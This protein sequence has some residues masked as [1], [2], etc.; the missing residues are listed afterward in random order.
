MNIFLTGASGFV[1]GEVAARLVTAGHSI[2]ALVRQSPSIRANDNSPVEGTRRV[3][4]DVAVAEMGLAPAEFRQIARDHDLVI[5]C[6]ATTRFDLNDDAYAAINV[7]GAT[8]AVALARAGDIPLLHISTAYVCGTR[9]GRI[10]ETDPLPDGGWANGYERSKAAAERIVAAS[11]LR[12]AIARPSIVVG[13]SGTGRVRDF[14][15]VYGLFKMMAEGRFRRIPATADASLDF[16][17]IDYVAAGIA[18][19]ADR[20]SSASGVY[21]L[22]SGAPI[23]LA[24]AVRTVAGFANLQAAI[25]VDPGEYDPTLLTGR[26]RWIFD[27]AFCHYSSYTSRNPQFDD[28]R[29][30][31]FTRNPR[32]TTDLEYFRKLIQHSIDAGFVRTA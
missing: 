7:G 21:H 1:G 30:R 17:P 19:L 29:F 32:P 18:E 16:V 15:A 11:G 31:A 13:D 3:S 20:I 22:V 28:S 12:H 10:A 25:L 6:A 5:H 26:E 14:G 9:D 27:N 24:A 4:G 8:Q 23:P 2:T